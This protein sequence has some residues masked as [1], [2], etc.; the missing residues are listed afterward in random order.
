ML[1]VRSLTG[2][3]CGLQ[4]LHPIP[5]KLLALEAGTSFTLVAITVGPLV[6][7]SG[8]LTPNSLPFRVYMWHVA[9]PVPTFQIPTSACTRPA[10]A[11]LWPARCTVR[12]SQG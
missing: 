2:T 4:P 5:S 1:L 3:V 9:N 12:V 11:S 10:P 7:G 6:P 8:T